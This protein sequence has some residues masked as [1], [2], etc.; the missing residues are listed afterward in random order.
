M[1]FDHTPSAS[2]VPSAE[3]ISIGEATR[4]VVRVGPLVVDRVRRIITRDG[5]P[6]HL[7]WAEFSLVEMLLAAQGRPVSFDALGMTALGRKPSPDGQAIRQLVYSIR[8]KLGRDEFGR[9]MVLPVRTVG[10][11]MQSGVPV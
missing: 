10:F 4:G 3:H 2:A 6:I 7:T 8:R 11:W 9:H 5:Q 1:G